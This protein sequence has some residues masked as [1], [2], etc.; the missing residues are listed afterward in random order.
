MNTCQVLT[1]FFFDWDNLR[2]KNEI[3]NLGC[4]AALSLLY[5]ENEGNG[6]KTKHL[7]QYCPITAVFSG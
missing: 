5:L 2:N 3:Q 7:P 4:K 1:K 6:S